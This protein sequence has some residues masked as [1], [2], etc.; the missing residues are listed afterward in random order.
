MSTP[1]ALAQDLAFTSFPFNSQL[2]DDHEDSKDTGNSGFRGFFNKFFSDGTQPTTAGNAQVPR[3]VEE[4]S[5]SAEN[6]ETAFFQPAIS[7]QVDNQTSGQSS[8]QRKISTRLTQLIRS[9][10]GAERQLMDYN[11][12]VFRQ[13]WMHD[14]SAKECYECHEKFTTFRRRH[15]CRFCGQI[16]C[17]KCCNR[18]ISGVELG[19]TGM[20]RLCNYC[21]ERVGIYQEPMENQPINSTPIPGSPATSD[22][23]RRKNSVQT[24]VAPSATREPSISDIPDTLNMTDEKP[25][26]L[27]LQ[28]LA[29]PL[30][31]HRTMQSAYEPCAE[32]GEPEWV[33]NLNTIHESESGGFL[34]APPQQGVSSNEASPLKPTK[35]P[36]SSCLSFEV[37]KDW[38][39][40]NLP[41]DSTQPPSIYSL[42]EAQ[43]EAVLDYLFEREQLSAATWKP[44][45]WPLSEEIVDTIEV[46]TMLRPKLINILD[47]VHIKKLH[48]ING[49]VFSKALHHKTML[50]YGENAS[51]L[52]LSGNISY[53]R[54]VEKLSS[55]EPILAQENDYLKNQVDRIA[56]RKVSLLLVE[57]SVSTL[58]VDMLVQA[59]IGLCTN[60]KPI[61]LERL[62]RSTNADILS[63]LDAQF[64]QPRIGFCPRYYQRNVRL[65]DGTQKELMVLDECDPSLGISIVIRASSLSELE[66]VKRVFRLLLQMRYS[67]RCEQAF[68]K[69]FGAKGPVRTSTCSVCALNQNADSDP[70]DQSSDF[71]QA[72]RH[73]QLTNSPL[74]RLTPPYLETVK[75]KNCFLLQYFKKV[76]K[77]ILKYLNKH[78]TSLISSL[79]SISI[80]VRNFPKQSNTLKKLNNNSAHFN[81]NL[82]TP[83]RPYNKNMCT[84]YTVEDF[85]PDLASRMPEFRVRSVLMARRLNEVKKEMRA[86]CVEQQQEL[87]KDAC[88]SLA[89]AIGRNVDV[90]NPY[91][92]QR[93]AFLY[94][95][96]ANFRR[97]Q[98]TGSFCSGPSLLVWRYYAGGEDM[99]VGMFLRRFCFNSEYKCKECDKTMLDHFRK[100]IH[101]RVCISI[102]TQT[103]G[104][105]ADAQVM[106]MCET[107]DLGVWD[108]NDLLAWK[109]CS[110]CGART[111]I[112]LLDM[113]AQ[114][115]SFAKF[116]DYLANAVHW[117]SEMSSQCEHCTFHEHCHLFSMQ[118][119]VT[120]FEVQPIKPLH[121][122][123][124]PMLCKLQHRP[125]P[126][127]SLLTEF[128]ELKRLGMELFHEIEPVIN[129]APTVSIL[130]Q[131]IKTML[132]DFDPSH[133]FNQTDSVQSDDPL[134]VNADGTLTK[135]RHF[136]NS[137]VDEWN[138]KRT[139]QQTAALA[140]LDAAAKLR[141]LCAKFSITLVSNGQDSSKL[142]SE[143]LFHLDT[144][145]FFAAPPSTTNGQ[146]SENG[147]QAPPPKPP[148]VL[149]PSPFP[150]HYHFELP[151]HKASVP[152]LVR[153]CIDSKGHA[154]P[155]IGSVVAFALASRDYAE[156]RRLLL[157]QQN[158]QAELLR[159]RGSSGSTFSSGHPAS[160]SWANN[161]ANVGAAS[162]TAGPSG[163]SPTSGFL[164]ANLSSSSL[165]PAGHLPEPQAFDDPNAQSVEVD[166][167]DSKA[168]Y[169]VKVYFAES[170]HKLR[171]Q[172][173][174]GGKNEFLRSLSRSSA[175][176]PQGGKS[177]A[178]FFRTNDER[179]VFKQM[180]RL[181][182]ESFKTCA[183]K[184]FDYIHAA[185]KEKKLTSLCKIYGVFRV[186]YTSKQESSQL[187]MDLLVMEYLFYQRNIKQMWDLKGSLRNRYAS[188][189]TEMPVLLDENLVQDLWGNQLY[190]HHHSKIALKQAI[191]NDSHFLS[192]LDIMDYSL[193]AGICQENDEVIVGIVDYMRTYTL[194][195]RVES[196][197][198]TALPIP[199]LPTVINPENYCKRFCEAIDGYFAMAPDVWTCLDSNIN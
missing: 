47:Y 42:F 135:A 99:T 166:F 27:S 95:A 44:L 114:N 40:A 12:S 29:P 124:A 192:S 94:C 100:I 89:K 14:S 180:S 39:L 25:L 196:L 48:R 7:V 111:K 153:D 56:S 76:P 93:R 145:N 123:F 189:K 16:F 197:V 175:W 63:S 91:K 2:V 194:D 113:K 23:I 155:D 102:T 70:P 188:A 57:N 178:S 73:V 140:E 138:D 146:I 186:G 126:C 10:S 52:L 87:K 161:L 30:P 35:L 182:M 68:V 36:S 173:F 127:R 120:V 156:K 69:M 8:P 112:K 150:K 187:K 134:Y 185:L 101:N 191:H 74:I 83:N 65:A 85:L 1:P 15:H 174:V 160:M 17:G 170:F 3:I 92:H 33:K 183:P 169:Y 103:I 9:G 147:I 75:G 43:T 49:V 110:K 176:S 28:N 59:Q 66:A 71:V 117:T 104:P 133:H 108:R 60:L 116:I 45:L 72:M 130:Q 154:T 84:V 58:A 105:K 159:K 122:L 53:E 20:L 107:G 149:L 90:L 79:H 143:A 38:H 148:N 158:L 136:I 198:K 141:N 5:T 137:L 61:I 162:A 167:A 22:K 37:R 121:I 78:Q 6:D 125:I 51:I 171:D 129:D 97:F 88:K 82:Q 31:D 119:T 115:L 54:V 64:L 26:N 96:E 4:A 109:Y 144:G 139:Q 55:L 128:Y 199:H 98:N 106:E 151:I 190:V 50:S 152:V 80:A 32:A 181:E 164:S 132:A 165:N 77:H 46:D 81:L 41:V 168:H 24:S 86:K 195:K 179:F 177:G 157:T 19:Y 172:V 67:S 13:Y 11:R 193:L 34:F 184:Y 131:L 163:Y 142:P 18:Q 21:L 118:G 62:A